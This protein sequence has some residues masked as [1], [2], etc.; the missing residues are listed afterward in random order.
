M[1]ENKQSVGRGIGSLVRIA[2]NVLAVLVS[3]YFNKSILWA[4]FHYMIGPLYLF[5]RL[6]RGSFV[7]GGFMDIVSHYF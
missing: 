6:L 5:Y 7:N 2:M 3:W 1:R 4:I